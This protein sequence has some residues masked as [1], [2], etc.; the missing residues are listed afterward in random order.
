MIEADLLRRINLDD[1]RKDIARH[2]SGKKE[3]LNVNA[4]FLLSMKDEVQ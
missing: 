3:P 1:I 2:K 4:C